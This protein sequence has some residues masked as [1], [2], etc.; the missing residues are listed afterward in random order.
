MRNIAVVDVSGI[1]YAPTYPRRARGLIKAGRARWS[2]NRKKKICLLVSPAHYEEDNTMNELY[3][4]DGNIV[5]TDSA[6]TSVTNESDSQLTVN[7]ILTQM[8][9][10]RSENGY[11]HKAIESVQDIRP[12]EPCDN[13]GAQDFG[14]QAKAQAI[15]GIVSSRENTN[16]KLLHMY[17][18]MYDDIK[19]TKQGTKIL[20]IK[21]ML[22]YAATMTA[23]DKTGN[24]G[25]SFGHTF[26]D[27]L[28]RAFEQ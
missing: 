19:P 9:K 23:A 27:L 26:G 11:I 5:A 28:N 10:I 1:N 8:E 12:H 7:Y 25:Q 6:T 3:N 2:D 13:S 17:E 14:S 22:E 21:D 4:N 24:F 18:R 15:Q 20:D 16:Q